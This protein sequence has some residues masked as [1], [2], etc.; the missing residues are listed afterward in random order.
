MSE[1]SEVEKL[2]KDFYNMVENQFQTKISIFRSDNGTEYFNECLENFLKEKGIQHQS[3]CRGTPKQNGIAERKNKHLLE[4]ACAIMF[5]MHV[6]KYLWGEAV[7]TASYLINRMPTR[8]LK[9]VTPLECLKKTFSESRIYSDLPL[10]VFGCTVFVH[11]PDKFRSKLDPRA[12]KCI[13][14]GYAPNRKGYQ[15]YNPQTRKVHVSM[16]VSFLEN[17]PYFSKDHIQG[18]KER[19]KVNFWNI[20]IIIPSSTSPIF[21][22]IQTQEKSVQDIGNKGNS[23]QPLPSIDVSQTGGE[24]LQKGELLV[25]TR[26]T[27]KN[28]EDL[29]ITPAQDLHKN[30]PLNTLGNPIFSIPS[31]IIPSNNEPSDLDLPIALRKGIR[32]C[33]IHPIAKYLS[34]QRLSNNHRAFTSKISH[35]FV[36][37]NIQEALD[38]PNWKLAIMEEMNALTKIGTWEVGEL[39]RD[40][41]TVGC[42]YKWMF[43]VKCKADGSIESYKARLVAKGFTLYTNLWD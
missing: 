26:K 38:D 17:Q 14:I 1:K 37:R 21:S 39:P 3:T 36:P 13:F 6:P 10:K 9:V 32:K 22:E 40:K 27:H 7:L 31:S 15:C 25:Y 11:I 20:P 24:I 41:K 12:E 5:S 30:G 33:T 35:L 16:D 2:F 43:T 4:V 19:E 42:N 28:G 34:Y 23:C 8:V 29:P 18:E